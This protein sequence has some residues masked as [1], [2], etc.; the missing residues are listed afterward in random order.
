MKKQ[1][2]LGDLEQSIASLALRMKRLARRAEAQYALELSDILGTRCRDPKRIEHLLDRMLDF[3]FDDGVLC[4]YRNLCRYYFP[5][6]PGAVAS[7]INAYR[8]LWDEQ[9]TG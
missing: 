3:G 4:L 7:Y 6:N 2:D 8:E 5:L 9:E 1:E